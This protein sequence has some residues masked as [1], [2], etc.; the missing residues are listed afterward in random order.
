[1]SEQRD[2]KLLVAI[3]KLKENSP[4][5]NGQLEDIIQAVKQLSEECQYWQSEYDN[6]M[7][8]YNGLVQ[9]WNRQVD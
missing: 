9:R 4:H 2:T 7:E 8:Q 6:L 1:M 5:Q 3:Q